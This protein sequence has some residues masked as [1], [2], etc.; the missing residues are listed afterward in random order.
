MDGVAFHAYLY[1]LALLGM[2]S[3]ATAEEQQWFAGRAH[4]ESLGLALASDTEAFAGHLRKARELTKRSVDTAI[5][6]D[7]KEN[8]ASWQENAAVR[9]SAFGNVMEAKL[10][11]AAGLRLAPG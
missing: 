9:E 3:Q 6:T 7:S 5:H 2:D 4:Y 11:G 1:A 8:A 10:A